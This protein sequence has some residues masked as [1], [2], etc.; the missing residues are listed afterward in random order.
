MD[1]K[2]T[3]ITLPPKPEW[4]ITTVAKTA[5]FYAAVGAAFY[6]LASKI[7]GLKVLYDGGVKEELIRGAVVGGALGGVLGTM[8]S[9]ADHAAYPLQVENTVLRTQVKQLA[10]DKSFAQRV[11]ED[12]LVPPVQLS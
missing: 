6:A 3:N 7:P 11:V 10:A 5:V 9:S 12:K 4:F 8:S 2:R 1:D